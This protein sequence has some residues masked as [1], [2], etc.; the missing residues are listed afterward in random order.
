MTLNEATILQGC[1]SLDLNDTGLCK[2]CRSLVPTPNPQVRR[3]LLRCIL[4]LCDS[5]TLSRWL[6]AIGRGGGG[7]V[8]EKRLRILRYTRYLSMSVVEFSNQTLAYL[9]Q[10]GALADARR[11]CA[12]LGLPTHGTRRALVHRALRCIHRLERRLP[13]VGVLSACAV[14]AVAS[15]YPILA[16]RT[17]A[18][19]CDEFEEEAN[20]I[21]P[22]RVHRHYPI[23]NGTALRIDFHIGA[24]GTDG[25][26][27][28]FK[29]P[30]KNSDIQRAKGQLDQYLAAY[31][32]GRLVVV[33]IDDG[34]LSEAALS[35][36][37]RDARSRGVH[38]V[39]KRH[40]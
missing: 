9:K 21:W 13:P 23:T 28:E 18:A 39:R 20:E 10:H 32:A 16:R 15:A 27:V 35:L 8:V 14:R 6:H 24:A 17:E 7:R 1:A 38:V 26:G 34:H 30:R 25:I 11:V 19:Y 3:R 5:A 33:V 36:F 22:A 29:V 4:Q 40:G 2:T 37:E 31:P 12:A